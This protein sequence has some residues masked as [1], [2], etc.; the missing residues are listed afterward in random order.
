ME[1]GRHH[2]YLKPED[3]AR[4]ASFEFAPK[5]IADGYLAGK[6]RTRTRGSSTEF[7]EYREYAEGD[8]PSLVDWRVYARTDRHYVRTFVHETN[9]ECH[10]FLDSSASMGFA[11]GRE[12]SK[13][14]YASFFSA[15]LAYLVVKT[16]NRVSLQMFDEAIRHHFPVGSTHQHLNNLLNALEKNEPGNATSISAALKRGFP[17]LK[18]KGTL[19]II[20]DFFDE[21]AQIFS[22][23]AGYLHRGFKI[24]L[25]HVLTP[26]EIELPLRGITTFVD[27]ETQRKLV[28]QPASIRKAYAEAMQGHIQ[29]LRQ[30]SIRRGIDYSLARTDRHYFELFDKLIK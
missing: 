21:P 28:A 11:A 3:V 22:A 25:I 6:H 2:R 13:L 14:D 27:M 29:V 24:H 26:E 16:G 15:A 8:D 4:L 30:F 17:L 18:R 20:S 10:I 7:Q 12:Q 1:K 9:V 23:L 5:L 19:V